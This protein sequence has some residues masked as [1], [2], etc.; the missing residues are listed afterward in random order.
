MPICCRLFPSRLQARVGTAWPASV[1]LG[2]SVEDR[3][4]WKSRAQARLMLGEWGDGRIGVGVRG[5]CWAAGR[6]FL[7]QA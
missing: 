5:R 7:A 3:R 2:V 1:A 6:E 4:D